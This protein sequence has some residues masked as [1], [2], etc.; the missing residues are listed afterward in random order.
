MRDR[1]YDYIDVADIVA[2]SAETMQSDLFV[3]QDHY[4]PEGH[5]RVAQH[6]ADYLREKYLRP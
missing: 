6:L 4:T 2:A 5:R 3:D 1:S